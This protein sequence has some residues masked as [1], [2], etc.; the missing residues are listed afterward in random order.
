MK[1]LIPAGSFFG[2][3]SDVR[4]VWT[5]LTTV[6][7]HEGAINCSDAE[8]KRWTLLTCPADFLPRSVL[9][10]TLP[11][12]RRGDSLLID[13]DNSQILFQAHF[14]PEPIGQRWAG[15]I[16]EWISMLEA[17]ELSDLRLALER[18][19]P[20]YA[21]SGLGP[22]FTPA[23]DDFITG[24]ITSKLNMGAE[25]MPEIRAFYEQWNPEKTTWFSAW[26]IKDALRGRIWRRGAI[27]SR[28]LAHG[29]GVPNAVADIQGWGHTSGRAW[30]AGFACGFISREKSKEMV[31]C[32]S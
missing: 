19:E 29:A 11:P 12:V 5:H 3:S 26:M 4:P 15:L 6:S 2:V 30:L 31:L 9:F 1:R 32:R 24:W 14:Q 13:L 17:Y 18:K 23:G 16:D 20:L 7:V 25:A 10:G 22:G 27:L 28:A 21:L 8:G